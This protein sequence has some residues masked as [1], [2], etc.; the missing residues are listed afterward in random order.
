MTRRCRAFI[1]YVARMMN[2]RVIKGRRRRRR[3]LRRIRNRITRLFMFDM[4]IQISSMCI[5]VQDATRYGTPNNNNGGN[6]VMD[7]VVLFFY[8]FTM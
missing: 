1:R 5:C 2:A 8:M 6:D 7:A 3:R 4:M